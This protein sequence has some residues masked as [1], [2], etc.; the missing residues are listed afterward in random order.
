ME[1]VSDITGMSFGRP[2]C[3]DPNG[4]L[5]FFG[6]RGGLFRFIPGGTPERISM[7]RIERRLQDVDLANYFIRLVYNYKDEGVHIFQCPFGAGGTHVAHWFYE[8]KAEGFAEDRFGST[9]VTN[10]QPT[11]VH[12]IDGD[13][14]DDRL[15]L[16]ACEDGYVRKWDPSAK[17]DDTRSDGTTKIAIDAYATIG[18]IQG[19]FEQESGLEMAFKGLTVVLSSTDDGG[20]YELYAAESPESIGSMIQQ[21]ELVAG[22]NPPKWTGVVGSY[23]W[24]RLRNAAAEE[25]M[26]FERATIYASPAG[27]AHP[28]SI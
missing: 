24:V 2:W 3:K 23:C 9:S 18:P 10:I 17:S 1:L 7:F 6:S 5:Y 27:M 28:R 26:A 4:V 21:G 11:A 20:R 15:L 8:L 22:R 12:V 13:D 25:H 19:P 14:F 16:I